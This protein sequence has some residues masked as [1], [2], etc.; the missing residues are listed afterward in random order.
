MLIRL[1]LSCIF[2]QSILHIYIIAFLEGAANSRRVRENNS[3]GDFEK[4]D[5]CFYN[6]S[7]LIENEF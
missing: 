1:L 6:K 4:P 7:V 2:Q 5:E 3:D